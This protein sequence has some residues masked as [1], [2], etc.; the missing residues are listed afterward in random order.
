MNPVT[1]LAA[2]HT[3]Q[4]WLLA[5]MTVAFFAAFVGWTLWAYAPGRRAHLDAC[6]R[7]PLLDT[8]PGGDP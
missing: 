2:E 3:D 4:G 8:T 6:A 1:R 7:L 5:L